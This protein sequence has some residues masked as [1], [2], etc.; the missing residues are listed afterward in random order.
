MVSKYS[1]LLNSKTKFLNPCHA[2]KNSVAVKGLMIFPK[3]ICE[4][5]TD[6]IFLDLS[7]AC[8]VQVT[9]NI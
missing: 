7:K 8:I 1:V 4:S 6:V 9:L 2:L 3:P 5:Q